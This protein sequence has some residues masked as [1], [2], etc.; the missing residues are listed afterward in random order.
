MLLH[1]Q[2]TKFLIL[3]TCDGEVY[4]KINEQ[5][6]AIAKALPPTSEAYFSF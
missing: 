1:D 2:V 6:I 3:R 4:Y 5:N